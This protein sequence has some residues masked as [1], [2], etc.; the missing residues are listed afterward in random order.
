M[1]SANSGDIKV[2]SIKKYKDHVNVILSNK[3]KIKL[4]FNSYT[5]LFLFNG[6]VLTYKDVQEIE[7][8]EKCNSLHEY[9][10]KILNKGLYSEF[11]IREKLYKKEK[12][13]YIVNQVVTLLKEEKLINDKKY[14]KSFLE[15]STSSQSG[16]NKI[17]SKLKERGIFD[18]NI[19]DIKF[20]FNDELKK[21]KLLVPKLEKKYSKLNYE[22][23]KNHIYSALLSKGF[24]KEVANAAISTIKPYNF[25]DDM[26]KLKIDYQKTKIRLKR[27]YQGDVLK[28]K[29]INCLLNKGYNIQD[30]LKIM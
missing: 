5:N 11:A 17:I 14:I 4:S 13:K 26:N 28:Q 16:Q 6:K 22:A 27:K 7:K 30:I 3:R 10:L 2:I 24:S 25:K 9:A 21:A 19:R 20:S 29:I 23:K 8:I 1:P 12:N 18:E 15:S